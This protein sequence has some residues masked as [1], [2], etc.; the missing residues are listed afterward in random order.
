MT[1]WKG[2]KTHDILTKSRCYRIMA[3]LNGR[4]CL[5][6]SRS[7]VNYADFISEVQKLGVE[8]AIYLDMGAHSSYSKY[9][10]EDGKVINLFG[11]RGEFA[12]TWVAF[13]K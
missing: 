9:R 13:Y 3:E 2:N 10:D 5:I 12:H 7:I 6:E 8:T 1:I 4:V 11:K